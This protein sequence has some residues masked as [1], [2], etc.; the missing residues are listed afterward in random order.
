VGSCSGIKANRCLSNR[1]RFVDLNRH[2]KGAFRQTP[3][4]TDFD[5]R[6]GQALKRKFDPSTTGFKLILNS[7]E[8][9]KQQRYEPTK[10]EI[11]LERGQKACADPRGR[12]FLNVW[13][14][15]GE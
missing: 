2:P 15:T 14:S 13:L 8:L 6:V 7:K 4:I 11:R 12:G 5:W 1:S 10:K 9:A 3:T